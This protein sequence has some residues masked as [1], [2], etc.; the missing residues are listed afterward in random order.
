[1]AVRAY[2]PQ[3]IETELKQLPKWRLEGKEIVKTFEFSGFLPAMG[4][5]NQAALVAEKQDH[6]P[7]LL[8]QYNKVTLRLSTHDAGGLSERD[9]RFAKTV[10]ALVGKL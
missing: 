7:D 10:D 5:V 3:E 8:I 4:F 1:M 2:N 6:H 9:F